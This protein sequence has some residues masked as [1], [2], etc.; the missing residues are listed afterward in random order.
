MSRPSDVVLVGRRARK[1]SRSFRKSAIEDRKMALSKLA[2]AIDESSEAIITANKIDMKMASEDGLPD[3]IQD[4]LMLDHKR[5]KGMSD[6]VRNIAEQEEVVGKIID[7]YHRPNGLLVKKQ[8]IPLGVLAMIFESRPNVVIDCSALAIKS[9]NAIILKGGKEAQHSNHV[10]GEIV[11]KSI[12]KYIPRDVVQVLSSTDREA[13]AGLLTLNQYVDLIIP[14]GGEDLIEMVYD[15]A[16]VPVIAHFKGICHTYVHCDA[17]LELA[18]KI[19]INAKVQR[20]GVCNA[21]ETL[22]LHKDLPKEF[23]VNLFKDY[24]GAG[25]QLKVCQRIFRKDLEGIEMDEADDFDWDREYLEKILS[26]KMVDDIDDAIIHIDWHGSLH[27]EAILAKDPE[28]IE[29]FQRSI[30]ASCIVVNASTR[31][32]DGGELGLG[33]EIGIST[34]KFHAYGPMGAEELTATRFLVEGSGQVRE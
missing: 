3:S 14:R 28:V 11:R 29:K 22:L 2:A 30:D 10:L 34:T 8:A 23:I 26:V 16:T 27:T 20:P 17:D 1:A 15:N 12:E 7:Q 4:R 9:G 25:V 21:M 33:A 6:A 32:N 18:H 24:Q 31:F 13:V 19:C 5:I